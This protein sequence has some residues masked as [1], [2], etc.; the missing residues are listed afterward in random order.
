MAA[1]SRR[2][3]LDVQDLVGLYEGGMSV[4]AMADRYGCSR[5]VITRRLNELGLPVRN[6]SEAMY[7]RQANMTREQRLAL[8]EKAHA[9]ARGRIQTEEERIKI[10][11][12]RFNRQLGIS[13]Y[14]LQLQQALAIRGIEALL[15]FP[16]GKYN[17]DLACNAHAVGVEVHG[18]GWHRYG[19]HWARR[20]QRTEYILSQGWKLVEIWRAGFPG[21]SV[22]RVADQILSIAN[23]VGPA[24]T[25][26]RQHW[27]LGCDGEPARMLRSDGYEVPAVSGSHRRDQRSGRY[28]RAADHTSRV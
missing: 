2:Y 25:V 3:N 12:A 18:G 22:E 11:Q 17:L 5:N 27:M 10:A 20:E 28:R 15:E 1:N 9:A 8:L 24:P 4:K 7:L 13:G 14:Q 23:G 21:W 16:V 19:R 26:G 6:S